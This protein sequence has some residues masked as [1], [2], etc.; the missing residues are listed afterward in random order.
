MSPM[1]YAESFIW[2]ENMGFDRIS[3]CINSYNMFWKKTNFQNNP[4]HVHI[5]C[6]MLV[7]KWY[8]IV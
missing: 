6:I 3:I 7:Q 1:N 4:E 2:S 5:L 8:S